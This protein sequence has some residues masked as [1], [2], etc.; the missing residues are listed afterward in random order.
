MSKRMTS[1]EI[2]NIPVV[3]SKKLDGVIYGLMVRTITDNVFEGEN[4]LTEVL[5]DIRTAIDAKT[6]DEEFQKV[7]MKLN[8][9]FNDDSD[10]VA[11]L[12]DIHYYVHN[13]SDKIAAMEK[14]LSKT[15]SMEQFNELTKK[16]DTLTD[17]TMELSKKV[18]TFD[19]SLVEVK[20]TL[21]NAVT[22]K[23]LEEKLNTVESQLRTEIQG[24]LLVSDR[25]EWPEEVPDGGIWIQTIPDE[26]TTETE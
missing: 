2:V 9:F 14:I 1:E 12:R 8:A 25:S 24:W 26:E 10:E 18:E 20:E 5:A 22:K 4:S 19:K 13:C 21:N 17:N 7:Q 16:V 11:T 15:V 23:E 6:S 3:L